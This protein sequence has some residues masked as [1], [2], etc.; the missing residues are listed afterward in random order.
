MNT[1]VQVTRSLSA[2]PERVYEAWTNAGLLQRWLA[3]KAEADAR[4]GGRFRLE[5]DK[6]EGLHVVTGEYRELSPARRIVMTW[7]YEGPMASSG[8]M[9]ALL[10]VD[11]RV[12][13][14]KTEVSLLHEGLTNPR[15]LDVIRQGAWNQALDQLDALL[16]EERT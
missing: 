6:P 3:P 12:N 9:E 1:S 10:T 13:G 8:K 2:S 11:F 4:V 16:S 7:I 15:Y 14:Q 5:V